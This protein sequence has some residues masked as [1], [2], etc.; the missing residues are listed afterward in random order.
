[1]QVGSS[2]LDSKR[3]KNVNRYAHHTDDRR[4]QSSQQ[5]HSHV[6]VSPDED[7]LWQRRGSKRAVHYHV[8]LLDFHYF[9]GL[10]LLSWCA[11][12]HRA[13]F[14]VA[15]EAALAP[16]LVLVDQVVAHLLLT[17][18]TGDLL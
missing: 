13:A 18:F 9:V 1:M 14:L 8:F 4:D 2:E 12:G 7:R 10:H 15:D 5:G 11:S 6:S 16:D 17:H 3:V